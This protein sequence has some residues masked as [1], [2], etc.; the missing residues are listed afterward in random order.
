[1]MSPNW[2]AMD[3]AT[4][5]PNLGIEVDEKKIAINAMPRLA[6][7]IGDGLILA[8]QGQATSAIET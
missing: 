3:R 6:D 7:V 5:K 1:M 4:R 8:D 2:Y